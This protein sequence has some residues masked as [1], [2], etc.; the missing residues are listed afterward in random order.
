MGIKSIKQ[1]LTSVPKLLLAAFGLVAAVAVPVIAYAWGPDRTTFT[2]EHPATYI[3]FDSIT[4]NPRTGAE[5]N[6]LRVSRGNNEGYSDTMTMEKGKTYYIRMYVHNNAQ[7]KLNLVATNVRAQLDLPIGENQ[8]KTGYEVNGYLWSDNS[9]PNEIWDNIV[10][11]SN[12]AFHVKVLSAKYYNNI[13][14]E[15]SGGFDLS[16]EL[17]TAKGSGTGAL[18]GYQQMDGEIPGCL[19]YSGYVLIKFQPV[20][21]ESTSPTPPEGI[22]VPT[23]EGIAV[24]AIGLGALAVALTAYIRSRQS[25]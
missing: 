7:A 17:F 21:K 23:I 14:T 8:W 15:A 1:V 18:L 25:R 11:R 3:T 16:N 13:R 20:F 19:E 9:K 2:M 10:L 6:F 24:T 22:A 4:D 12:E 5:P